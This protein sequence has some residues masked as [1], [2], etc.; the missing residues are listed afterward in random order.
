MRHRLSQALISEGGEAAELCAIK[1][2]IKM[3]GSLC[4]KFRSCFHVQRFVRSAEHDGTAVGTG[5]LPAVRNARCPT[6]HLRPPRGNPVILR[7]D[8]VTTQSGESRFSCRKAQSNDCAFW[9]RVVALVRT[10]NFSRENTFYT[11]VIVCIISARG[12][13]T[14]RNY[15]NNDSNVIFHFSDSSH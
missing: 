6:V 1:Y 14:N 7:A 4:A 13:N 15:R 11:L 2:R 10:L 9:R 8:R 12:V 5:Q 3:C